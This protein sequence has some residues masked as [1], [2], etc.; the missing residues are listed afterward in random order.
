MA[1]Y[2]SD[3]RVA[4]AQKI[5]ASLREEQAHGNFNVAQFYEKRKQWDGA[6]IYYNE[7]LLQDPNSPYAA[8]A[9]QRIDQL[10]QRAQQAGK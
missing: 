10:K 8:E 1:F 7:V 4:Q 9:R 5:I 2:P 6:R 3:A